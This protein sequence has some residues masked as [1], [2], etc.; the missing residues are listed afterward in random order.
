M[1]E[2]LI[3]LLI[4]FFQTRWGCYRAFFPP[5]YEINDPTNT[6]FVSFYR[7][8]KKYQEIHTINA[9]KCICA[10][11]FHELFQHLTA[12]M[13]KGNGNYFDMKKLQI[14]THL[15]KC[16]S[17]RRIFPRD[18][19][20]FSKC[21]SDGATCDFSNRPKK[22]QNSRH[23]FFITVTLLL[24]CFFCNKPYLEMHFQKNSFC[25][26]FLFSKILKYVTDLHAK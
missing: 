13:A 22:S 17:G 16:V 1:S 6:F 10:Q 9:R 25:K 18:I 8:T 21:N 14:G 15:Y 7:F 19:S 5:L 20:N 4:H 26:Y 11:C 2:I 24:V 3:D 23:S 12:K